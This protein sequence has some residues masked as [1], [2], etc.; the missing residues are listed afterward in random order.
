MSA[1]YAADPQTNTVPQPPAPPEAGKPRPPLDRESGRPPHNK[2]FD[3][4]ADRKHM[5]PAR[6][7]F[8]RGPQ[9]EERPKFSRG[10]M[11]AKALNL[12]PEQKEKARAIMEATRPKIE[13]VREEERAKVKNVMDEALKELRPSLTPEQQAVLDDLQKLRADK[14]ALDGAR[15]IGKP[16]ETP[17]SE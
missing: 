12:T 11:L 13:A 7:D 16:E 8:A 3:W 15:K 10:E 14:A 9:G 6:R 1:L 17:K 4:K 2:K 5:G